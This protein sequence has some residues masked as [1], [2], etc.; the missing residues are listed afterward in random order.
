MDSRWVFGTVGPS[1]VSFAI[2]FTSPALFRTGTPID[3]KVRLVATLFAVGDDKGDG[4][5]DGAAPVL[6]GVSS[7][8]IVLVSTA[9][10]AAAWREFK[11]TTPP[12]VPAELA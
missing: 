9:A 2:K 8:A 1:P 12:R 5:G 11:L 7:R 4:E 6:R 3:V 10:S